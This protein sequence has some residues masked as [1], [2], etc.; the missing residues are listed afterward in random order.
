MTGSR[1]D[2]AQLA[3]FLRTRREAL[4]PEDVGLPRGARR[5]TEGLRRE[6]VAALS[7]MSA[8]YLGRM[9]Q[10]R[11][12]HPSE[13]MLAALARGLR[14]SLDERDHLFRLGG[15]PTPSRAGRHPH[16][17]AGIM[18]ILDR[19]TDTPAMVLGPAGECLAVTP[20]AAAIFGDRSSDEGMR[21]SAVYRWFAEPASRRVYP[22]EDRDQ[23]GAEM[24]A[25]LRAAYARHG[26]GSSAGEVVTALDAE[27]AE[28]RELWARHDV[29]HKHSQR[30][31][32]VSEVGVLDVYCTT[33]FDAGQSQSLLVFTA[34]T[35]ETAD[36]LRLLGVVGS[37][38][39]P[40][41]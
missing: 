9:E 2:R 36:R 18:R 40:R 13:P 39:G 27:S 26:D 4:Q 3:D 11:G 6:E 32:L 20:P 16:V 22:P 10:Q 7:G 41:D 1:G 38:F 35:A 33:L 19:L 34:A 23:R 21:A 5:R 37:P 14:L 29:R 15:F 31:R 25:D 17:D 12:P 8:D 24:V 30:K 28:F